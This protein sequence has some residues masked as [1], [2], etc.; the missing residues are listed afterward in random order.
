MSGLM[1]AGGHGVI[2]C[3]SPVTPP[4]VVNWS[5]AQMVGL[6]VILATTVPFRWRLLPVLTSA[7]DSMSRLRLTLTLAAA[8]WQG[9][10]LTNVIA[11]A[12]F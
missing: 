5:S 1:M 6:G 12:G 9:V 3:F 8:C 10:M 4:Q 11:S 7:K 2:S